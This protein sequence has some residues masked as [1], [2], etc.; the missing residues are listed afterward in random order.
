MSLVGYKRRAVVLFEWAWAYFT[1]QR[2]SRVILEVPPAPA[3]DR[4]SIHGRRL[5]PA[6]AP[7]KLKLTRSGT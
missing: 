2:R 3:P 1:W 5:V 6:P 7:T 4:S